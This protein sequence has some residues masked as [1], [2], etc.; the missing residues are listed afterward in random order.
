MSYRQERPHPVTHLCS[1][2]VV[3]RETGSRFIC[4]NQITDSATAFSSEMENHSTN[5][6]M[7]VWFYTA[8]LRELSKDSALNVHVIPFVNEIQGK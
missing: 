5:V 4:N 3:L 8:E 2:A 6:I 1:A 7:C